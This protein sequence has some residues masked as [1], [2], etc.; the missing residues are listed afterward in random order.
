MGA[1]LL[2]GTVCLRL[3]LSGMFE[4]RL[5]AGGRGLCAR[6][7]WHGG[8]VWRRRRSWAWAVL[9][10]RIPTWPRAVL[11]SPV[12]EDAPRVPARGA[13]GIQR[14][15]CQG[16][17]TTRVAAETEMSPAAHDA[18]RTHIPVPHRSAGRQPGR[19]TD[20][21]APSHTEESLHVSLC[22]QRSRR[23]VWRESGTDARRAGPSV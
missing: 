18:L 15:H 16:A 9:S 11:A 19:R 14:S 10:S 6:L 5:S 17:M 22:A 1:A 12:R 8:A 13:C 23:D 2:H 7:R 3:A 20:P 21:C 4:P